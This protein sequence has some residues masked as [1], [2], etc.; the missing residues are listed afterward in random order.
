[1]QGIEGMPKK[2]YLNGR[3]NSLAEVARIFRYLFG[4]YK[5]YYKFEKVLKEE[6]PGACLRHGKNVEWHFDTGLVWGLLKENYTVQ[7]ILKARKIENYEEL[8]HNAYLYHLKH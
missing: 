4:N 8:S 1:M 3:T 2:Y 6:Q 5:E 7:R